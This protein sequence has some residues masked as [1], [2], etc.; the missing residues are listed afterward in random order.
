MNRHE[1]NRAKQNINGGT[2]QSKKEQKR[3][4]KSKIEQTSKEKGRIKQE[5]QKR[6][7]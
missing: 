6:A 5:K 1:Q 3:A 7:D 4:E 2:E